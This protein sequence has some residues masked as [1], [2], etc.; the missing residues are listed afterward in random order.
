MKL[1]GYG[2]KITRVHNGFVCQ[3]KNEDD[4]IQAEVISDEEDDSLKGGELLLWWIIDYFGI[5]GSRHDAERLTITREPGD[6]YEPPAPSPQ[7][8]KA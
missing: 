1:A 5:D 6:K 4:I 8:E 2:V 3:F 7:K